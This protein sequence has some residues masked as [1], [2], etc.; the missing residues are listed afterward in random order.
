MPMRRKPAINWIGGLLALSLIGAAPAGAV[1]DAVPPL[2]PPRP[3]T[4]VPPAPETAQPA[5]EPAKPPEASQAQAEPGEGTCIERLA[6]L[7]VKFEVRPD[8]QDRACTVRETVR[9]T[10]L[11]DDLEIS[12]A[13]VMTCPL[14]ENL[15]RWSREVLAVEAEKHLQSKPTKLFV[16]TSYQCRDQR[17]GGKLSEHAFGNAVDIMGFEF[18]KRDPLNIG[19]HHEESP[20]AAFQKAVRMGACPIFTTVLGP[21]SDAAHGDH[22]HL[23]MRARKGDYRICQ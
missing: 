3:E 21:G 4:A 10:A 22:L 1:E 17:S 20:E 19:T 14:A 7:G 8:I 6:Q 5:A 15:V 13:A 9:V 2:P 18:A 23:D 12:P 11:P 16:G